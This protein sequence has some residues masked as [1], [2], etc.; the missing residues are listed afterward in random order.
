MM[1]QFGRTLSDRRAAIQMADLTQWA[2]IAPDV[3]V[4]RSSGEPLTQ[5]SDHSETRLR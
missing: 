2:A 4:R 3:Q 5:L 1:N